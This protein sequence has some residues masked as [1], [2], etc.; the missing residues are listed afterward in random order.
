MDE[1]KLKN[2]RRIYVLGQGRLVN[3]AAA[4][5]HPPSVMDMSFATQALATEYCVK[6]KGKLG[7]KVHTVPVEVEQYVAQHKLAS[8]GITIDELTADA[9][10]V[11]ERLGTGDVRTG[12]AH[13]VSG[14]CGVRRQAA[15]IHRR[16]PRHIRAL[17]S[18]LTLQTTNNRRSKHYQAGLL[19]SR[20]PLCF[21]SLLFVVFTPLARA[22]EPTDKQKQLDATLRKL[23]KDIAEVRG[24]AFKSPVVAKVIPRPPDKDKGVQGYYSLKDKALFVYDDIRGNYER[25][26]LVHEMVHALQDQHFGLKKLHPTG[27]DC[28]ADLARAALIE[29]DATFTMIEVLKKDQPHV[30]AMLDTHLE[31]AKNLQNAFLY[32]QG[33]RYVKALKEKG[34][35]EAVNARTST[36]RGTRRRC[37]IRGSGF[38]RSTW[39]RARRAGEYGSD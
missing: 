12:A 13:E 26:V 38:R 1:Y 24:L 37:C 29:G 22:A 11:H 31:K 32:G 25:G 7:A 16:V 10:A 14:A 15:A 6:N 30:L 39:G 20:L 18:S 28:D 34:G 4:E 35:W 2:G 23:E 17:F 9:E 3:L 33:A 19:M 8:M 36:R 27:F 21:L 5:G